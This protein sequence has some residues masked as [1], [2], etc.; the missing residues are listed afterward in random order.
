MPPELPSSESPVFFTRDDVEAVPPGDKKPWTRQLEF[1]KEINAE[2][3]A[4]TAA[5][6]GQAAAEARGTQELAVRATQISQQGGGLDGSSLVDGEARID[7]T[8]GGLQDGG[9]DIDA[10]VRHLVYAMN[11]ALA[12][13]DDVRGLIHNRS[14]GL[15]P[16]YINH[17]NA[18][19]AEWNGWV[20]GLNDAVANQSAVGEGLGIWVMGGGGARGAGEPVPPEVTHP[21][22]ETRYPQ[23]TASGWALPDDLAGKIR[24]K[25][26]QLAA[27]DAA[28]TWDDIEAEIEMYRR[29]MLE[30]ADELRRLGFDPAEEPGGLFTSSAVA[31]Q[32]GGSMRPPDDGSLRNYLRTERWAEDAYASFREVDDLPA[33]TEALH[34]VERADGSRGFTPQELEAIKNHIFFEEHPLETVDGGITYSRYDPDADMAEAWIRLRLGHFEEADVVLLEHELAEHKYYQEHPGSPYREAHQVAN[35]LANWESLEKP[36]RGGED[37]RAPW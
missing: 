26:L 2:D 31:G 13:K 17:L 29:K 27:T 19:I 20:Q 25:Y 9:D 32:S 21:S 18:A 33:M 30:R 14:M 28:T 37:Y 36:S 22:G 11:L 3:I 8:R 34:D 4:A 5:A 24:E 16:K 1:D 10:V 12:T 7:E 23:F 35:E 6:Y 15:D